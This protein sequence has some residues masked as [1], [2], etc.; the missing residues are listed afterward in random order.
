[1]DADVP[2]GP[3]R[4]KVSTGWTLQGDAGR[5]DRIYRAVLRAGCHGRWDA[6]GF[7]RGTGLLYELGP[8]PPLV[9]R[10]TI[11]LNADLG[12]GGS[13]IFNPRLFDGDV[14]VNQINTPAFG[15]YVSGSA[16]PSMVIDN[17]SIPLEH[18][19]VAPFRGVNA[20]NYLLASS[21]AAQPSSRVTISSALTVRT[22]TS[23][24]A[25]KRRKVTR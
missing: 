22:W 7:G 10:N 21:G 4:R 5:G 2:G 13:S 11:Q 6:P 15:R 12:I 19:M 16:T 8:V 20:A 24:A 23:R 1:M 17:S 18:R 25:G 3:R 9:W 14:Y